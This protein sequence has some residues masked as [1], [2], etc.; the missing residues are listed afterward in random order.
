MRTFLKSKSRIKLNSNIYKSY[1]KITS[2]KP[3]SVVNHSKMVEPKEEISHFG[4]PDRF[5]K[6]NIPKNL[7]NTIQR[8]EYSLAPPEEHFD[9]AAVVAG[10]SKTVK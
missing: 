3:P 10:W 6:K 4:V 1:F 2:L 5:L 9:Q 7:I 8:V